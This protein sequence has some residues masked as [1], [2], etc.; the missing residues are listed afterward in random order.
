MTGIRGLV[1]DCS[2]SSY[3]AS[4]IRKKKIVDVKLEYNYL[5]LAET[6]QNSK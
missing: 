3:E 5:C 4:L 1:A 6:L 2:R